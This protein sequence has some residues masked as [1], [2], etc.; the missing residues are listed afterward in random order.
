MERQIYWRIKA[1]IDNAG[2]L[3][4]MDVQWNQLC[5]KVDKLEPKISTKMV[6]WN[7]PKIGKI[8]INTDGSIAKDSAGDFIFAFLVPVCCKDHNVAEAVTAQYVVHWFMNSRHL[9]CTIEMDSINVVNMTTN[10]T[11][12]NLN[13]KTIVEDTTNLIN[14]TDLTFSQ[15][16]SEANNVADHLIKSATS[17]DQ[18]IL[19]HR[20]DRLPAGA[21]CSFILDKMQLLSIRIRYDKANFFVS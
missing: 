20:L 14:G 13:L 9:H 3:D 10:K 8:K 12:N 18:P 6:V 19:Y 21:K 17:L 7:T 16:Y 2:Y 15:C 1:A 5:D 11:S 4:K